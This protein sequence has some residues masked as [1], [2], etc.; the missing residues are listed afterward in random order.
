MATQPTILASIAD[1][2]GILPQRTSETRAARRASQMLTEIAQQIEN[3][4]S[5]QESLVQRLELVQ[6][7]KAQCQRLLAQLKE[8]HQNEELDATIDASDSSSEDDDGS[9]Q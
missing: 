9:T 3:I 8:P 7:K 1:D 2:N 6:A 5:T 4:R